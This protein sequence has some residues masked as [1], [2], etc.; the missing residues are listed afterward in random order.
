MQCAAL[1]LTQTNKKKQKTKTNTNSISCSW[2]S[3]FARKPRLALQKIVTQ[4]LS[5]L[6]LLIFI[7]I[8]Q[9]HLYQECLMCYSN[10]SS[11][12]YKLLKYFPHSLRKFLCNTFVID[13][14]LN[15]WFVIS[16]CVCFVFVHIGFYFFVS[17][18][19]M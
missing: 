8:N 16:V 5:G 3:D 19:D 14:N 17:F 13:I 11:F 1:D 7:F 10:S 9:L 4:I 12:I 2:T 18:F 15:K 6:L